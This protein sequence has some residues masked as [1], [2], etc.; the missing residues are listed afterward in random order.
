MCLIGFLKIC[1]YYSKLIQYTKSLCFHNLNKQTDL[2]G[3]HTY[4]VFTF[5]GPCHRS[6]FEQCSGDLLFSDKQL[7]YSV[8][9]K[10]NLWIYIMTLL[11]LL[12]NIKILSLNFNLQNHI[13]PLYILL[14]IL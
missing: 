1:I 3:Q 10:N 2:R 6:S 8:M 4:I 11:I 7:V 14:K 5:G 12:I 13:V 9:E